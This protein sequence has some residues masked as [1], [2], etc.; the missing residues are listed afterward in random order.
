M[1]QPGSL[2]MRQRS[3]RQLSGAR[4]QLRGSRLA[5]VVIRGQQLTTPQLP[6]PTCLSRAPLGAPA[7]GER[8]RVALALA[9][10]FSELAAQ[11]GRLRSRLDEPAP[12]RLPRLHT[13]SVSA[14]RAWSPSGGPLLCPDLCPHSA[15]LCPPPPCSLLVLDEVMQ[16]LDGEGCLRVAQLLKQVGRWR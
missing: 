2:E 15:L 8:R 7:G 9:L 6:L 12:P 3:V 13:C 1:R 14:G 11:R 16:H 5:L 4:E 10:G